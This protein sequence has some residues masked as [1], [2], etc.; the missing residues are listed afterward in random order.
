[1]VQQAAK[2]VMAT[3]SKS[4]DSSHSKGAVNAIAN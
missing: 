1:M 3:A 4:S 2:G